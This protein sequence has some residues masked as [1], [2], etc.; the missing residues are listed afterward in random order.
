ML[1]FLLLTPVR[2]LSPIWEASLCPFFELLLS[3]ERVDLEI[4]KNLR[5]FSNATSPFV[6]FLR[7]GFLS[8]NIWS[9]SSEILGGSIKMVKPRLRFRSHFLLD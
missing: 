1:P 8:S 7:P 2:S 5:M 4:L 6:L 9:N 3:V